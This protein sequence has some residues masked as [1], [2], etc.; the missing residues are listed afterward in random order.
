[1]VQHSQVAVD[2]L[3]STFKLESVCSDIF[4]RD[5]RN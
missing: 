4:D 3:D 5:S 2:G 1:M